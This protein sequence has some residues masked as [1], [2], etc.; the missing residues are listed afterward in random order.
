MD[1]KML[2]AEQASKHASARER[3]Y[4][5]GQPAYSSAEIGQRFGGDGSQ[6]EADV[7][8][9]LRQTG[10]ILG[11]W[12]GR[13]FR[14]PKFQFATLQLDSRFAELLAVLPALR[15]DR[16]GWRRA[17]WLYFPNELLEDREPAAVWV[18]DPQAV[19]AAARTEFEDSDE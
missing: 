7:A 10:Q 2:E 8:R 15:E 18:E 14:H 17:F 4:V 1:R 13:E 16:T 11:I 19:I 12:N 3:D 6:H 5:I 9:W